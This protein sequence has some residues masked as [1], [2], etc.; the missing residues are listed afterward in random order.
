MAIQNFIRFKIEL[1]LLVRYIDSPNSKRMIKNKP[2][3]R[4]YTL[5]KKLLYQLSI[6][7]QN[8]ILKKRKALIR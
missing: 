1:N 7:L 8:E 5:P 3:R 2:I 6:Y 4:S